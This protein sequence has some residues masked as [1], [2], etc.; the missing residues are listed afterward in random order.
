[1][2]PR[3]PAS[4]RRPASC[5]GAKGGVTGFHPLNKSPPLGVG[6]FYSAPGR[7]LRVTHIDSGL[8]ITPF[9]A[10]ATLA[11][12]ALAPSRRRLVLTHAGPLARRTSRNTR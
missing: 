3:Q 7:I 12:T 6:E 1:M 9:N 2:L 8:G 10:I 5:P 4:A 11:E